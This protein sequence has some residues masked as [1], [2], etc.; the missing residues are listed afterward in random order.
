MDGT[1]LDPKDNWI[2]HGRKILDRLDQRG[3][4]VLSLQRNEV[5][6]MRQLLGHLADRVVLV[7][8]NGARIFE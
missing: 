7:V 5:H 1:L 8:A 3:V 6:R 2:Y 4:H